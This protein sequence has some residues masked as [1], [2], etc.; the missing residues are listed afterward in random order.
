MIG[1]IIMT[2]VVGLKD[3]LAFLLSLSVGKAI[4]MDSSAKPD[5]FSNLLTIIAARCIC[6]GLWMKRMDQ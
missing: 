4:K 1:C 5:G 3:L 6:V 2:I